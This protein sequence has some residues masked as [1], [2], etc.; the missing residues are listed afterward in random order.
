MSVWAHQSRRA[1]QMKLHLD[2]NTAQQYH[3]PM[4]GE[5]FSRSVFL[6]L[7]GVACLHA[8]GA[9]EVYRSI[10]GVQGASLWEVTPN[11]SWVIFV[12]L[13][14]QSIFSASVANPDE[15]HFLLHVDDR[16]LLYSGNRLWHFLDSGDTIAFAMPPDAIRIIAADGAPPPVQVNLPSR[17]A[18]HTFFVPCPDPRF[19][20]VASSQ[21]GAFSQ[22]SPATYAW[23]IPVDGVGGAIP[24][25][26]SNAREEKLAVDA[27]GRFLVFQSQTGQLVRTDIETGA[28]EFLAK[29]VRAVT[30]LDRAQVCYTVL[31]SANGTGNP[32]AYLRTLD[33]SLIHI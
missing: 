32:Q 4:L 9:T 10:A 27:T 3:G 6:L 29:Y 16:D 25:L 19:A 5:A 18:L 13:D 31:D 1:Q 20:I 21:G 28:S 22:E 14:S 7:L 17:Q 30:V 26:S 2:R 12:D 33:L 23:R 11:A 15:V 24:L 8:G